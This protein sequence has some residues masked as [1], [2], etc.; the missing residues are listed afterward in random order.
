[1]E[2]EMMHLH[3]TE[4]EWRRAMARLVVRTGSLSFFA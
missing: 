4:V 3:I 2:V 1:M